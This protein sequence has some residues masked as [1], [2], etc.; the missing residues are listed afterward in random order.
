MRLSPSGGSGIRSV[1]TTTVT[2]QCSRPQDCRGSSRNLMWA[3]VRECPL[4]TRTHGMAPSRFEPELTIPLHGAE[5]GSTRVANTGGAHAA[6]VVP[7]LGGY[8]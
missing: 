3:S 6:H 8:F 2:D 1:A 5:G 7:T 4:S